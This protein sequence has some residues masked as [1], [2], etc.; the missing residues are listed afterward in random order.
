MLKRIL[1]I[2]LA[3]TLVMTASFGYAS[4][5]SETTIAEKAQMA[6]TIER[7]TDEPVTLTMWMDIS[8]HDVSNIIG[9]LQ[10]MDILQALEEKTGVHI[11][12]ML[13][14]VGEAETSFSLMLA[15]GN[16]ADI[17]IGFDSYYTKGGDAAIEEGIIYDLKDLVAE[18]A[19]NYEAARTASTYRELGTL[20]DEGNMPYFCEPTYMDDPGLTYGGAIIRQDLL[21]DLGMATPVTFDDWH[22]FL[23]RCKDELGM[24]RGL[25]LAYTGISKYN[26]FNAAFGFEMENPAE[27]GEP[28]YVADGTVMYG[29]LTEGYKDYITLMSQWYAEGL[30]DPDF[31]STITFDDGIAMMSSDLCA[32]TSEHGGVLNYVNSLGAAVNEDFNFVVV[33]SPVLNEGDQ[34]HVGYMKSGAGLGKVAAIST[35]CEYPE[36]AVK[37][38]DQLYS[39][40]GFM[41]CNYGTEGKTYNMVDGVP[42]YTDLIANND[43]GTITDML[44]AYAAP[45]IWPFESVLGRDDVS[46]S[47][48]MAAVWDTNSDYSYTYPSNATLN[49]EE[50]EVYSDLYPEIQSY[51]NE[52]TVMFIMGLEPLESYDSF[53]ET[54][55][56]LGAQDIIDVYQSA[57]DRYVSR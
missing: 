51:V 20:T 56:S 4:D 41:L 38:I 40:E 1:P 52:M 39:D 48:D 6:T 13:A 37:F 43:A 25:G 46:T 35:A 16:Y 31:T 9:D 36:I 15:S 18:Y 57:Y 30:I 53:V 45:I 8:S 44:C 14:P 7:V 28:V 50:Q 32:A 33:P 21:D 2:L 17:I 47:A 49:V 55:Y 42:V 19:P 11:E 54:L 12:L 10:N 3:L 22:T 23:T 24:T 5:I 34:L 26:A 27:G 29:P